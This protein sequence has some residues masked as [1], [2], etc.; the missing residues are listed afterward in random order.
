ME[1]VGDIYKVRIGFASDTKH[2]ENWLID[3]V[4]LA[5]IVIVIINADG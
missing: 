3:S 5:S 4:R 1:N 2:D